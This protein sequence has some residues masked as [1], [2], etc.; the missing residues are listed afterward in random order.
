M[1]EEICLL[2]DEQL[3]DIPAVTVERGLPSLT[4][5]SK[6]LKDGKHESWDGKTSVTVHTAC[7]KA[8]TRS[9]TIKAKVRKR[10]EEETASG[11]N[12]EKKLRGDETFNFKELCLYCVEPCDAEAEK[13]KPKDRRRAICR[14]STPEYKKIVL[15]RAS[16]RNDDWG[17]E[18]RSRVIGAQNLVAEGA[19]YHRKCMTNF[20]KE[21][22]IKEKAG[23]PEDPKVTAAFKTICDF[24]EKSSDVQFSVQE[25]MGLI[26][27]DDM[28]EKTLKRKLSQK[29]GERVVFATLPSKKTF[30]CLR[31]TA[32]KILNDKWYQAKEED[33]E[34]E[35]LRI[36]KAAAAIIKED[37]ALKLFEVGQCPAPGSLMINTEEE[38]PVSLMTFLNEIIVKGKKGDL[39]PWKRKCTVFAHNIMA[40]VRPRSFLSR[41]QLGLGLYLHHK[42]ASCT[43]IKILSKIGLCV[44]YDEILAYEAAAAQQGPPDVE[45]RAFEQFV[46]DSD[47]INTNTID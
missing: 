46:F 7:R 13:K 6:A 12:V 11:S 17:E 14:V 33:E 38:V 30:I 39:N 45:E 29:Y 26:D 22:P 47:D 35:R 21:I 4:A 24:I 16:K 10:P 19:Q 5:A 1:S 15:E 28:T 20:Y 37:I 31:D 32:E 9:S 34:N 41:I 42:F 44:Q 23:R 27:A 3:G 40:A 25:L 2:C 43:M 36:V 18:I 8:Y